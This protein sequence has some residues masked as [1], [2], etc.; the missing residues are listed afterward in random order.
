MNNQN[1][2]LFFLLFGISY[3]FI[4]FFLYFFLDFFPDF[5]LDYFVIL[6]NYLKTNFAGSALDVGLRG[7]GSLEGALQV[8]SGSQQQE[9]SVRGS[10]ERDGTIY[11]KQSDDNPKNENKKR[12]GLK[13]RGERKKKVPPVTE[14][15]AES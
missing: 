4:S 14:M 1:I 11:H 10:R 6:F 8:K 5:F 2:V 7:D 15:S 13:E 3:S 9:V 12:R